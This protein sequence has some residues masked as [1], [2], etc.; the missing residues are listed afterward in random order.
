MSPDQVDPVTLRCGRFN[1]L[2]PVQPCQGEGKPA[3]CDHWNRLN[4]WRAVPT[5]NQAGRTE[6][7][8]RATLD[9]R[10]RDAVNGCPNR[11]LVLPISEQDDC[12]CQGRELTECRAGRGRSPGKVTLAECLSCRMAGRGDEAVAEVSGGGMPATP[13]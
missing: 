12:G 9:P 4:T 2:C 3:A 10:L 1:Q 6:V 5:A 11:G 8:S 13:C 7:A